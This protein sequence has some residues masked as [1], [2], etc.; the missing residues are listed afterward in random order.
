MASF[1]VVDTEVGV[2]EK[3]LS[4]AAVDTVTFSDESLR[5]LEVTNEDGAAAIYFTVNG[6]TPTVGGANTHHLPAAISS[7]DVRTSPGASD[8]SIVVKLISAGTPKYSVEK[9]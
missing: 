4:A 3:T 5:T 8:T 6:S 7:R 1:T 2:Y 9:P